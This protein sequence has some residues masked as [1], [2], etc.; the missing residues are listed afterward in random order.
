[1]SIIILTVYI[2]SKLL[3]Q[4]NDSSHIVS[5]QQCKGFL[6]SWFQSGNLRFWSW[7][8]KNSSRFGVGRNETTGYDVS[9]GWVVGARVLLWSWWALVVTIR[10]FFSWFGAF[11]VVRVTWFGWLVGWADVL[12]VSPSGIGISWPSSIVDLKY[13]VHGT[14]ELHHL[15]M[16]LFDFLSYVDCHSL[17]CLPSKQTVRSML[18]L[19]HSSIC[20]NKNP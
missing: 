7:R 13:L 6:C 5:I 3:K 8:N 19:D 15:H 18:V 9:V 17:S 14:F 10:P 11:S 4:L 20:S 2:Q 16:M 12:I 1:M